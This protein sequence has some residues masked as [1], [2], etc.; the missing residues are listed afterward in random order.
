MAKNKTTIDL[1]EVD[2]I[3]N[4]YIESR[5]GFTTD[6]KF[7]AISDFNIKIVN[8]KYKRKND[9]MFTL[10]K[11]N[12]WGGSYNGEFNYGKKRIIELNEKNKV[13]V[14]G[15]EFDNEVIDI[16]TL[17]NDLHN[18]PQELTKYLVSIFEKERKKHKDVENQLALAKETIS[19]LEN[20]IAVF[21][22]GFTNLFFQSNSPN[23]SLDNMM[24]L[25]K[26]M[27]SVCYDELKNM[28][29]N[30]DR[31]KRNKDITTKKDESAIDI[32]EVD[33]LRR[34]KSLEEDGF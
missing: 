28:F 17:V 13:H 30:T 19:K 12:F 2:E 20:K 11:Y 32:D 25:S 26:S 29:G 4:L 23:T 14:V 5:G 6:L 16:I 21:E 18:K 9:K 8:D 33:R 22:N 7:K 34:L 27:D 10:Y 15:H 24:N 31:F 1:E 3:V